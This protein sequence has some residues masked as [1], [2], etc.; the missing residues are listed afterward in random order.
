[1]SRLNLIPSL[2]CTLVGVLVLSSLWVMLETVA[3]QSSQTL[4]IYGVGT[5]MCVASYFMGHYML[6]KYSSSYDNIEDE[7]RQFYTLSNAIKSAL[8][9]LYTPFAIHTLY[10]II[11]AN[12]WDTPRIRNMA[13]L[14]AIP[15]LAA[16]C[17]VR[18]MATSTIVHHVVVNIFAVY[19]V[20]HTF[21]SSLSVCNGMVVYAIF[22]VFSY[23]VNALLASRFVANASKER[24]RQSYQM[25]MWIYVLC[26]GINWTWQCW[27]VVRTF[28][29]HSLH[30]IGYV[31]LVSLLIRDDVILIRWLIHKS[32]KP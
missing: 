14:Y 13:V 3:I 11:V 21:S 25:A 5:Y 31:L 22:S 15:D 30:I 6:C 9:F 32:R 17:V 26:C 20:F 28:P 7:G 10:N 12:H 18:R 27:F 23:L 2:L 4:V 16:L 1:M 29:S 19:I 24:M 8:L